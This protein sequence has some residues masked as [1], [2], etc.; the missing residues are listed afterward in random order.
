MARL[1]QVTSKSLPTKATPVSNQRTGLSPRAFGVCAA[2]G[3]GS[4]TLVATRYPLESEKNI[5][6]DLH[7]GRLHD[8]AQR[9]SYGTSFQTTRRQVQFRVESHAIANRP[10]KTD[11]VLTCRSDE[12]S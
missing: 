11:F 2:G 10:S 1:A 7:L 6:L 9:I 4:G 3:L 5:P 12:T 8:G